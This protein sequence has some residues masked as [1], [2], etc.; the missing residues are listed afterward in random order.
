MPEVRTV[1]G[2]TVSGFIVGTDVE[3]LIG[4]RVHSSKTAVGINI[5]R[6]VA[7][8]LIGANANVRD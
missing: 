5:G 6:V 7:D 4:V 3:V 2:L 8:L 1:V